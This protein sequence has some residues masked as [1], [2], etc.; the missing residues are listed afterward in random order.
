MEQWAP[1]CWLLRLHS[2]GLQESAVRSSAHSTKGAFS[3]AAE[4]SG[5]APEPRREK[6]KAL[7][8][9]ARGD[10][11]YCDSANKGCCF[12]SSFGSGGHQ[13]SR[14]DSRV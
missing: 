7:G 1:R 12:G 9:E 10:R 14:R 6:V 13:G 2:F 8:K 3:N 11:S 5:F 4:S